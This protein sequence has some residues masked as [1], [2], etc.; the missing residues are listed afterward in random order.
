MCGRTCGSR[1]LKQQEARRE[2]SRRQREHSI[3]IV[4]C[5]QRRLPL[6]YLVNHCQTLRLLR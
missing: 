3:Y 4:V 5:E 2:K 1:A 6:D